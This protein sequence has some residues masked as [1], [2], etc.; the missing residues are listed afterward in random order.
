MFMI[1]NFPIILKAMKLAQT[2]GI[3]LNIWVCFKLYI[4]G[5]YGDLMGVNGIKWGFKGI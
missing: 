2:L 5:I 4:M 3:P 1:F